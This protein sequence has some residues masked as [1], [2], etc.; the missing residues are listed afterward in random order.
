VIESWQTLS[1]DM[2]TTFAGDELD[3]ISE[4]VLDNPAVLERLQVYG[5][6]YANKSNVVTDVW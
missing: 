6:F 5:A 2:D 4:I 3:A 1:P